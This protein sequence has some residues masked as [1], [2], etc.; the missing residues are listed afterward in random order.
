M[1]AEVFRILVFAMI[2]VLLVEVFLS[3]EYTGVNRKIRH[4]SHVRNLRNSRRYAVRCICG[5]WLG[6]LRC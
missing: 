4:D 3:L 1:N 6:L 2:P 5:R